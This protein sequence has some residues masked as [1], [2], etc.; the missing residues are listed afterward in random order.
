[1]TE[2]IQFSI[3]DSLKPAQMVKPQQPEIKTV[4]GEPAINENE[5]D[6]NRSGK[7]GEHYTG[8]DLERLHSTDSD[9]FR[10]IKKKHSKTVFPKYVLK[11]S[12]MFEG[13]PE[14]PLIDTDDYQDKKPEIRRMRKVH[15]IKERKS[16]PKIRDNSSVKS[17]TKRKEGS[18]IQFQTKNQFETLQDN[19]EE[20]LQKKVERLA[21][22]EAPKHSLKKCRYCNFKKR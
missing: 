2:C 10:K 19:E 18:V 11:L 6:L 4:R 16:S 12:N 15:K 8:C 13:L 7:P 1:M 22:L 17:E 3:K 5:N 20:D 14:E 9:G 21:I